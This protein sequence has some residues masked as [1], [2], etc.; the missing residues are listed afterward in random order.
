MYCK[1]CGTQLDDDSVYC[2]MCRT[3]V[4]TGRPPVDGDVIPPPPIEKNKSRDNNH[5][6]RC[7]KCGCF[8]D[9]EPCIV[10]AK[11]PQT[12]VKPIR[13]ANGDYGCPICKN[14][15][16]D[17]DYC[18][19]C[20]QLF[21]SQKPIVE[22][23]HSFPMAYFNFCIYFLFFFSGGSNAVTGLYY[24]TLFDTANGPLYFFYG[25]S[26]IVT[27]GLLFYLRFRL[28][29]FKTDALTWF[30]A[31]RIGTLANNIFFLILLN[32]LWAYMIIPFL[33]SGLIIAAEIEYF[34]K[35]ESLFVY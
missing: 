25:L 14:K 12:P 28:A 33:L 15:Q 26:L 16:S 21:I 9:H 30:K 2:H 18:N 23:K 35:R 24:L 4:P 13:F 5:A 10:C 22:R 31:V 19:R 34:D 32:E 6:W 27:G 1:K 7:S 8:I 20:G 29:E 11:M 17:G 3:K